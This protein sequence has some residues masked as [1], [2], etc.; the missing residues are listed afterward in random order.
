M[1]TTEQSAALSVWAAV[2]REW[3]KK[4]GVYLENLQE[5]PPHPDPTDMGNLPFVPGYASHA[6]DEEKEGMLWVNSL[7]MVKL[8]DDK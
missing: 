1:S 4:G 6:F 5:A 3:E 8:E 2:G 7:K